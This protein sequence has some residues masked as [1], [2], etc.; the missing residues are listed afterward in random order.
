MNLI[1]VIDEVGRNLVE[2]DQVG[3]WAQEALAALG[4]EGVELCVVLVGDERIR[5]LN[6]DYLGRDRPTNVI[7][8]PQQEGE[9]PAGNHLGDVVI[10]VE[11]AAEEARDAHMS[12]NERIRQLLVHGICHLA[13]FNH[14]DVTEEEALAMEEA[15]RMVLH[16]ISGGKNE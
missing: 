5:E 9:G 10:S 2:A 16:A 7:S 6:R 15:E 13:G 8:F 12:T 11:R 3:R 14:E 4:K 1:D